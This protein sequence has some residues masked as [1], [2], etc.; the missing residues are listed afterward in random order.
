[1]SNILL[2]DMIPVDILQ[3]VQDAFSEYTGM[4]ALI[5][6]ANGTPVTKG[7][8]FTKFCMEMTRTSKKGGKRCEAC[9]RQGAFMTMQ[10]GKPTVYSCHAG[11][12]DYA[13]PI[14]LNG[15]FIG[16][17]IGGQVRTEPVDE[18]KMRVRALDYGLDPDEYVEA[19]K[20]TNELSREQIDKAA[21]F[22]QRLAGVLS[23]I[24]YKSYQAL[25]QN[26]ELEVNAKNKSDFMMWFSGELK[27]NVSE[28]Y[29][30]LHTEKNSDDN[31]NKMQ[32]KVYGLVARTL[33]LGSIVEDNL[34]YTSI[35]NGD[36]KLWETIYNIRSVVDM[37][38]TE[39][40]VHTEDKSN[41]L[42]YTISED[43]PEKVVGDP[44]RVGAIIGKLIEN[45]NE[46][47]D[48]SWIK[49]DISVKRRSYAAN[50][51]I[52]VSDGGEIIEKKK[53]DFMLSY[54]SSRGI[55]Q[56]MNEELDEKGFSLVG[57]YV[58]A[59]SGKISIS[60]DKDKYTEFVI[61]IPQLEAK[62]GEI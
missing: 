16:S 39:Y 22:L 26:H 23:K 41:E 51:I 32:K 44:A 34:D 52:K 9:D 50:L 27:Q 12:T 45:S 30:F 24:A 40:K 48:N 10:S 17:F 3:E 29:S 56:V 21:V 20:I 18:E 25:S 47:S 38:I 54:L 36:F 61:T 28:I 4:A 14:L 42:I 49:V 46:R 57:Y 31:N 55:S 8:G 53:L 58:N 59:M 13:A 15:G 6:D 2:T 1:M 43:V 35:K 37:K 33:E 62:G 5:T 60:S 7:S 11:L 19:A